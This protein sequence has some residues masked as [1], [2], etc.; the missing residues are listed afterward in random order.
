MEQQKD[1]IARTLN[2]FSLSCLLRQQ[3]FLLP[4]ALL[5]YQMNGLTSADFIFFQG[6]FILVGLFLEVPCGYLADVF[7][8]KYIIFTSFSLFLI[9]CLLWLS[10][11]GVGIV[12]LGE[13]LVVMS[14]CMF[15][16][17]Y[18]SYIYEYLKERDKTDKLVK[19]CGL[20][21]CCLNV[22]SGSASLVCALIYPKYCLQTLLVMEVVV[23]TTSLILM[24]MMPKTKNTAVKLP[25]NQHWGQIKQ[26]FVNTLSNTSIRPYLFLTAIFASSTYVFIW[27]FQPI[28]RQTNVNV[29]MF[30]A[31]YFCNF[32]FRSATSYTSEWLR[33]RISLKFLISFIIFYILSAFLGLALSAAASVPAITLMTIFFICIGIGFQLLFHII[34]I[35]QIQKYTVSTNRATAS[36][37]NNLFSQGLSGLILMSFKFLFTKMTFAQIYLLYMFVYVIILGIYFSYFRKRHNFF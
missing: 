8:K 16:G 11:R 12:V 30:G 10:F 21:N 14:R 13:L 20:V 15:Q 32:F 6:V 3:T 23:T 22:G 9:R 7:S 1:N 18:D 29:A 2:T 25:L 17:I 4:V 36:S 37:V 31:V 26:T 35:S 27:N 19:Y 24:A 5:W 28:M 34:T 33:Q